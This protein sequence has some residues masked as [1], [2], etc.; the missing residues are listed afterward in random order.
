MGISDGQMRDNFGGDSAIDRLV[1]RR[2]LQ[3]M[4]MAAKRDL[5]IRDLVVE[6]SGTV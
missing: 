5:I 3:F 4:E 6:R 2:V 1:D